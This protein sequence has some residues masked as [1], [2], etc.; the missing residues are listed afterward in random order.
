VRDKREAPALQNVR[1]FS[2]LG[3]A[4]GCILLIEGCAMFMT[5]G[6]ALFFIAF[7]L[8]SGC[9]IGF[10]V[11]LVCYRSR[12]T[13]GLLL[14]GALFGGLAFVIASGIAGWAG[15]HAAFNNGVRSDVAPWG[16]N[17]WFRN[18]IVE[19]EGAICIA[20]SCIAAL[21][22]GIRL[23]SHANLRAPAP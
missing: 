23:R 7:K 21:L 19:Y 15:S 9:L 22:A 14:R 2:L 6:L 11:A 16:E 10:F 3:P 17:L 5:P 1:G 18:R 20:S 8:A 12:I 13:I 4:F